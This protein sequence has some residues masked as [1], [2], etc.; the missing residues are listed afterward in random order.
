MSS[1][2]SALPRSVYTPLKQRVPHKGDRRRDEE[3]AFSGGALRSHCPKLKIRPCRLI[4]R[5]H[6]DYV[7]C[8]GLDGE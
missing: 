5:I 2:F 6:A 3:L 4:V 1:D 7:D 8:S